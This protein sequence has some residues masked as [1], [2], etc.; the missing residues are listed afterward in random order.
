MVSVV[1]IAYNNE[2]YIDRAIEGVVRQQVDFDIELV[3]CDDASTDSTADIVAKWAKKY[4]GVIRYSRNASNLGVQGNYLEAFRHCRGKY[5]AMCDADDYWICRTKL[6]RQVDYMENHSECAIVFHRVVNYF[7]ATG[8]MSLSNGGADA[9]KAESDI[10]DLARRNV[11]TNM[12]VLYRREL[13][14]LTRLPSWLGE[15]R[16]LDYAMHMLYAAHGTVH[17]MHRPMGVYRQSPQAIWSMAESYR[18]LTMA[19]DVRLHLLET[20]A[21]REDVARELRKASVNTVVAMVA[22][23][24]EDESRR[25]QA[26]D[27]LQ[28]IGADVSEQEVIRRASLPPKK[29]ALTKRVLSQC[30]ALVS[31]MIPVPRP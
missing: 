11:I 8:E 10:V 29:K 22:A 23:A 5:M 9:R 16:L 26:L 12:S 1:M 7:E 3:I 14:D 6:A 21:G 28:R 27:M 15:V 19:L 2:R 25:R 24:G 4:P 30:R 20:F 13:V 17:Y 31:R 18:R